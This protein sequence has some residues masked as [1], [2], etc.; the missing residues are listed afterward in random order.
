MSSKCIACGSRCCRSFGIP[1][2]DL[3]RLRTDGVDLK[4]YISDLEPDPARY[5]GLHE[6]VTVKGGRFVVSPKIKTKTVIGRD[7]GRYVTVYSPCRALGEDGLCR[8]YPERPEMCRNFDET[9]VA[10]YGVPRGC[11]YDPDDRYG[12]D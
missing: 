11:K 10:R 2:E 5:F 3:A 12:E 9:T 1:E 8:I 4:K 7:G 6:G